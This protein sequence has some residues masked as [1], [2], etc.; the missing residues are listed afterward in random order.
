MA[1]DFKSDP[2]LNSCRSCLPTIGQALLLSMEC[3]DLGKWVAAIKDDA[4]NGLHRILVLFFF[5]CS[6]ILCQYLANLTGIVTGKNPAQVI[7]FVLVSLI[8]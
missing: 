4:Y 6:G 5:N 8:V 7:S 1:T 2:D 3:M